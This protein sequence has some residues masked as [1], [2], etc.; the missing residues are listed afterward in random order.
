MT[1]PEQKSGLPIRKEIEESLHNPAALIALGDSAV[2]HVSASPYR[3]ELKWFERLSI[4]VAALKDAIE[5]KTRINVASAELAL[6]LLQPKEVPRYI[7]RAEIAEV[8][9]PTEEDIEAW[10]WGHDLAKTSIWF[11]ALVL[12]GILALL[13]F[14][15]VTFGLESPGSITTIIFLSLGSLFLTGATSVLGIGLY[16]LYV[17][18]GYLSWESKGYPSAEVTR[19]KKFYKTWGWYAYSLGGLFIGLSVAFV[20]I[21]SQHLL[22]VEILD[23]SYI[24]LAFLASTALGLILFAF[25]VWPIIRSVVAT[26]EIDRRKGRVKYLASPRLLVALLPILTGA[27]SLII[28]WLFR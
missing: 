28:S 11:V 18:R 14:A 12:L 16:Q 21:I 8:V 20:I 15:V 2:N 13:A 3:Y 22:E 9:E 27:L 19:G 17:V 7:S 1:G 26:A 5:S 23:Y 25:G 4:A 6:L 24:R 10:A